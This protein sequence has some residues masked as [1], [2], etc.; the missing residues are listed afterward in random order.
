MNLP[1][2]SDNRE[3]DLIDLPVF[4]VYTIGSSSYWHAGRHL[5]YLT[6]T[7]RSPSTESDLLF[8]RENLL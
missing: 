7:T 5:T 2:I 8:K 3:I 1:N 6:D 4:F